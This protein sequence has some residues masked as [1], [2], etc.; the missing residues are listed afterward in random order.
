MVKRSVRVTKESK[1]GRN[2]RFTDNLTGRN[3][4]RTEFIKA[5]NHG[6]YDDYHTRN[7]G[8]K[9]TPVSNPDKSKRNNLD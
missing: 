2:E 1:T 5:I 6:T 7:I 3:M 9:I 8:G 4:S